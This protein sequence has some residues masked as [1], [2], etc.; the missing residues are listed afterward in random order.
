MSGKAKPDDKKRVEAANLLSKTLVVI[1][2][3]NEERHIETCIRSLMTDELARADTQFLVADGGSTDAT[4]SIV[5][6]LGGEFPNVQLIENPERLQSAGINRAVQLAKQPDNL[7]LV[8]C[9]AHS[10]YPE[11][12]VERIVTSLNEVD[13]ASLVVPMDAIG[14]GCFGKANA[15]IVDTPLGSGGSAHRAGT[16]SGYIDHGHH[17]GFKL[18]TFLALGGY[19][20]TF[21][22][23]EDA[24]YDHR[25][26]SRGE[27]IFLNADIR[28]QYVPR[29]TPLSLAKQYF[30]YGKGR[31]RNA[32]KHGKSLRPRQAIPILALLGLVASGVLAYWNPL[33]LVIPVLYLSVL[34]GASIYIC[35]KHRSACG[36]FA[37]LASGI[38]HMAW[39][40]GFLKQSV[41]GG[42]GIDRGSIDLSSEDS[43][44]MSV[45]NLSS[46]GTNV[47]QKSG[48]VFLLPWRSLNRVVFMVHRDL[49]RFSQSL[50]TK[51]GGQPREMLVTPKIAN[52]GAQGLQK[53]LSPSARTPSRQEPDTQSFD[54]ALLENVR[55]VSAPPGEAIYAIG[56]VHGQLS[57]LE[58]L[59]DKIDSDVQTL[60]Q[61][62]K[63]V[64]VFLGDYID[65]GLQ[66][67]QV[68]D[69]LIGERLE[70]YETIFI[71][72]NH[73]EALLNFTSEPSF[74][75]RW[76]SF[77]GAETLFSYGV[78]P[79]LRTNDNES[80]W[81]EAWKEF[82]TQIPDD[83][84]RFF[85]SLQHYHIRGDFIFVHAGLRPGVAF[86]DQKPQ[87][88]MWIRDRFLKDKAEFS[89]LVVHGHTPSRYPELDHRRMGLDTGAYSTGILTAARMMGL[90]IKIIST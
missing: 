18:D 86:S 28:I 22:H 3:L 43:T 9:D 53:L 88:M 5:E 37:G 84:M 81:V 35:A 29:S 64:I 59:L 4:R 58:K 48:S 36:L 62:T 66:S 83:H 57:L 11:N 87:D 26:V 44:S 45:D 78:T 32:L 2:A 85:A 38:M 31:A 76:A 13:A 39:A 65:R 54:G 74:G 23:N 56:D 8:R 16:T 90:E 71:A 82:K 30:N 1:P 69:L 12:F 60:P 27:R 6:E 42:P 49:S 50:N 73:E 47:K 63:P 51:A 33:T 89:K 40:A 79:P 80:D 15:W 68:I 41:F 24:E 77:G 46:I 19:D 67:K 34:V 20:P 25:V 21:S 70:S 17:A 55:G 52:R 7:F 61:G 14:Q 72:G 75:A 10:I